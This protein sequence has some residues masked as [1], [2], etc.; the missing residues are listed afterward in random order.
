VPPVTAIYERLA[1]ADIRRAADILRPVYEAQAGRDGFVSLEVSPYLAMDT[2]ATIAEAR[3]LW[4][5][6]GREN[7]MIKVPGTEAGIPAIR[8]LIGEGININ[9]TL[10]FSQQVYEQV[11][12]AYLG[13]LERLAAAGRPLDRIVS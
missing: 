3:R 2:A 5:A 1:T 9:I 4:Q 11:I 10:L 7:L 12:V 13:G 6:V 8:A